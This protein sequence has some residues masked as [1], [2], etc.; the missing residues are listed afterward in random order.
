[1]FTYS[2]SK[3]RTGILLVLCVCLLCLS[4]CTTEQTAKD[5]LSAPSVTNGQTATA[6]EDPLRALLQ[7]DGEG[8]STSAKAHILIEASTGAVLAQKN[9]DACLPMASTTKIMTAL[10]AIEALPLSTQVVIP[11]EAV[12]VEGSSIYLTEGETLTVEELLYALLLESANDAAVA[13]ACAVSGTVE[14]FVAR[15]DQRA[16]DMGLCDTHF[17]NPHGLEADGHYTTARELALLT[18][19]AL[20][21]ETFAAIVSTQKQIIRLHGTEG[22]RALVNH[23]RLLRQYDGCIGVKTGYTKRAGRCL[24]SAAERDGV[25]L[26]AVTLSDPD[27]WNDHEK[28]L[29]YGFSRCE[30]VTLSSGDEAPLPVWVVS[31]TREYALVEAPSLTV[32]L[33]RQRGDIRRIVELPRFAYAPLTEGQTLGRLVWYIDTSDGRVYIGEAPLTA[34]Y[35]IEAVTYRLSLWER[36]TEIFQ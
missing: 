6:Y 31:G 4:A 29:D 26:I 11:P 25:R 33:P 34:Q 36:L 32:V 9:A 24:V 8:V 27:D 12:G 10:V 5:G 28:L 16:A 13:L 1:M 19:E 18:R 2:R 21:N 30:S 7:T 20:K 22:V 14:A 17:C 15:M 3:S 35:G 23:N